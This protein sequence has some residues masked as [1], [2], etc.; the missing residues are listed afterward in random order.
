[1]TTDPATV[2]AIL[3]GLESGRQKA[4]AASRERAAATWRAVR[5]ASDDDVLEG[6]SERGRAGRIAR[7][8]RRDGT[9]ISERHVFRLLAALS[10]CPIRR[11]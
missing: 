2:A 5:R 7:R 6:H 11:D 1:V 9:T 8:L 10:V 3:A 4:I